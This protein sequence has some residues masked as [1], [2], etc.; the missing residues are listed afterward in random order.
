MRLNADPKKQAQEVTV[1]RKNNKIDHPPLY[2]N[3]NLRLGET[4]KRKQK[5]EVFNQVFCLLPLDSF[6]FLT[7]ETPEKLANV[8]G[9]DQKHF[10]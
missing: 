10:C 1:S 6:M 3:Q 8:F 4:R 9:S 5:L 7:Y 2:F